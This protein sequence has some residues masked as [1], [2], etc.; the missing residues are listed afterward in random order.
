LSEQGEP[1]TKIYKP[2]NYRAIMQLKS[3]LIIIFTL[4]LIGCTAEQSIPEAKALDNIIDTAF[5]DLPEPQLSPP[6]KEPTVISINGAFIPETVLITAGE[7]V[8]WQS[9]DDKSHKIS[10]YNL[11]KR[12]VQS[13]IMKTG[14]S[15][16]HKFDLRG[17]QL[18]VDAIFGHRGTIIVEQAVVNGIT[19]NVIGATG[20]PPPIGVTILLLGMLV[21]FSQIAIF[22]RK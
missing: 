12:V 5:E 14:D 4:A 10:C 13:E 7:E 9:N 16:T 2:V 20:N 1:N 21:A 6:A 18:C 15:F 22:Y 19:G 8:T 11:R 17:E 3:I